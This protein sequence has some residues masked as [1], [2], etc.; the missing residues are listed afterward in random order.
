MKK[1]L[2]LHKGHI[3]VGKPLPWDVYD[4]AEQLLLSR[5]YVIESESQLESLIERGI[6]VDAAELEASI[7]RPQSVQQFDPFWVWDDLTAKLGY[8]LAHPSCQNGFAQRTVDLACSVQT[9]VQKNAD[10]AIAIIMTAMDH[11]RYSIVHSLQVAVLCDLVANRL[12]WEKQRRSDLVCAALT[13]NIGM[14]ELQQQLTNQR[15]PLTPEQGR[16]VKE[17]PLKGT[18]ILR[19]SGVDSP[20]WLITVENHHE[21]ANG[22]GYPRGTRGLNE[23]AML[24][25][26]LDIYCAKIS[27]R[28]HRKPMTGT[29]AERVIFSDAAMVN[30]NPFIP[31]LIK[32]IGVYPPGTFVKLING[33]IAIVHKRSSNIKTPHVLSLINSK[34]EPLIE[35]I[36]RDTS[37]DIYTV[38]SDIPRESI[39]INISPSR[40][41][42]EK[43]AP[44]E[45][46]HWG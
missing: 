33:E 13:M 5:G 17:H 6:Y 34:G 8:H 42:Q 44:A 18:A 41:W 35:P 38:S 29:Q 19:E 7:E 22:T 24:L 37:R 32:E 11:R 30:E 36:R 20:S 15:T 26:T 43:L 1:A 31:T 40:F 10:A 46:R 2:K 28:M 9:L 23:E 45:N 14:L 21:T 39:L 25:R 27:P 16:Q 12:G 3:R 4:G